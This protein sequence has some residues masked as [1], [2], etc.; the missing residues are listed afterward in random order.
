[1]NYHAH[2]IECIE[3][4]AAA[5]CK[6]RGKVADTIVLCFA[7]GGIRN[8]DIPKEYKDQLINA[9]AT[10]NPEVSLQK[11]YMTCHIADGKLNKIDH[12][13]ILRKYR[14]QKG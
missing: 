9:F 14:P 12:L 3:Q 6:A 1:M 2:F 5:A 7:Q 4:A 10:Y 8:R 11:K 13:R